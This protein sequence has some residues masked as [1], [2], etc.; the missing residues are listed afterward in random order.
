MKWI[1]K[2]ES[3]RYE[4]AALTTPQPQ[5]TDRQL[6]HM[7]EEK[8]LFH[9]G[10]RAVS[11]L[12]L[13]APLRAFITAAKSLPYLK[14]G[15][16]SALRGRMEVPVLDAVSIGVSILR[17][18]YDMAGSV[19]FLL[20]VGELMEEYTHRKSVS[21]LAEAMS[22]HIEKVWLR[23][24]AGREILTDI[25]NVKPGDIIV[26][27][28]G[29]MIPLDGTVEGG[30]ASVNQSSMT[31]ESL[32]VMKSEGKQVFAGTVVE[33]GEITI[34]VG[35]AA[36]EGRYDRIVAMIEE[37]EKLKSET[38][39][40][41]A[42][43]ADRLV[44]YTFGATILTYL[45]TRNVTRAISIL[46]V[47]FCC[48]LKLSM[49]V[50]EA[51]T[52]LFDKTGTLTHARPA[53]VDVIGFDGRDPREMLRL[54][55]CLEEHYPHSI[56]GAVVRRA[57]KLGL[58]HEERHSRVEYIVAHGIASSIN[59]KKVRIG[60]YHFI[61]EDEHAVLPDKETGKL[62]SLPAQYSHLYLAI[63]G[64]LS[65]VILIEDPLR[66]EAPFVI[67]KLREL[68]SLLV[69]RRIAM[70]LMKRIHGNYR[71]ILSFNTLLI[72]LG[73]MGILQ[74][75]ATALLH[76]SSTVLIGMRSMTDLL[77]KI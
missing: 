71:S 74:P 49:P 68:G 44:P 43:L 34:S 10:R 11:R 52:V 27:R 19:M 29:D 67:Q 15:A 20:G 14:K 24:P 13:P 31:G 28:T 53:V 72:A 54:A 41:A 40:R 59:G 17:A 47:D 39:I 60:S 63:D 38:E 50:A 4:S 6:R 76:N 42:R 62:H 57:A 26:V 73:M 48:A 22:L 32:P 12:L 33:D 18:D 16:R 7:F 8:M 2:H 9:I 23:G 58:D 51:Q 77:P 61:F 75:T 21:D 70:G 5:H 65:A 25:R 35:Q 3:F 64:R 30:E 66:N 56:A 69:L 36:G 1:I 45:F 46:M 37:S 55:A